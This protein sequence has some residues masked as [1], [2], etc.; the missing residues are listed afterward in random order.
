MLRDHYRSY[1]VYD[2]L[3]CTDE[4]GSVTFTSV[5]RGRVLGLVLPEEGSPV[6]E[7]AGAQARLKGQLIHDPSVLL[8]PGSMLMP[9]DGGPVLLVTGDDRMGRTPAGA[10]EPA[11]CVRVEWRMKP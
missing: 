2:A 5:E 10:D 1:T 8:P 7:A 3:P 11:A 4:A 9:E 6:T